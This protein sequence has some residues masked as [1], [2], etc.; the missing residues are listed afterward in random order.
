MYFTGPPFSIPLKVA[1][2]VSLIHSFIE[3]LLRPIYNFFLS[4]PKQILESTT[5]ARQFLSSTAKGFCD[6][7]CLAASTPLITIQQ[8]AKILHS[9]TKYLFCSIT[10]MIAFSWGLLLFLMVISII[11]KYFWIVSSLAILGA[12]IMAVKAF[13]TRCKQKRSGLYGCHKLVYFHCCDQ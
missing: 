1:T 7:V 3:S 6:N 11:E 5:S 10:Y 8:L 2:S 4:L 9:S 12:I 13:L